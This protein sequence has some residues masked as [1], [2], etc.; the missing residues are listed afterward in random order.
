MNPVVS[1]LRIET[2]ENAKA[3]RYR[4]ACRDPFGVGATSHGFK[5]GNARFG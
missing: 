2:T 4:A 3:P 1:I 5:N